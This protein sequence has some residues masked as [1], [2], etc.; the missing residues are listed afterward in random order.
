MTDDAIDLAAARRGDAA[1][2]G[3]LYDRHAG[4]IL[5]LCRRRSGVPAEDAVQETFIRAFGMLDRI[6]DGSRLRPWL[7]A[8]A[9]RVCA[10]HARAARRRGQH[11]ERFMAHATALRISAPPMDAAS[12]RREALDRLGAALDQLPDDERLAIHLYYLES[13]CVAAAAG[14]LNVSR[15][16]FYKLLQK[17]RE[18]LAVLMKEVPIP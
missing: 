16:G 10:E 14:A 15:S 8:I 2:L 17:A 1:A 6:E 3:R 5:S 11:E 7:Y 4:V 13:D 9:R 12:D 18:R